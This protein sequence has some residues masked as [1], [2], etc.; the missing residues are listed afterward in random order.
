MNSRGQAFST[1][2]LLISA[3]IALAILVLLLNIIGG[4][5]FDAGQDPNKAAA[6][7]VTSQVNSPSELRTTSNPVSFGRDDSLNVRSIAS[8]SG[9]VT[10]DQICISKGD[11]ENTE[12][13]EFSSD[14]VLRYNGSSD[15]RIKISVLCDTGTQLQQ[16][17]QDNGVQDDWFGSSPKC[18]DILNLNQTACLIALRYA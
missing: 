1:F 17:L 13:F 18:Q 14:D 7:L 10:A 2:Q 3:I 15:L 8:R 11:H 6:D 12:E 16:D 5:G 4:I 9:V